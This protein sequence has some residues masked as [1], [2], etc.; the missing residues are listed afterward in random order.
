MRHLPTFVSVEP[1]N[2]CNLRCP[3]CPVGMANGHPQSGKAEMLRPE[4]WKT[5]LR[6][7]APYAHTMQFYFQ[8]E[9]L[10]NPD[11]PKMIHEAH[12]AGLYTIVST[13]AQ[14]ITFGLA[15]ALVRSGLNRI[16]VSLDGISQ[17]S[18]SAYRVGGDIEKVR[19]ALRLLHDVKQRLGS[20][21]PVI[22]WQCLR[23]HTNEHEWAEMRRVYRRWGADRITLKTAQLYDY[24]NGN[25]LMPADTRYA[26][27][28]IGKDGK[29]HLK[30]SLWRR[31]WGISAPC[32]RL[33]SGCVITT[34]GEVLP[35]CYDKA[36]AHPF[37]NILTAS[38]ATL[39]HSSVANG[40]RYSV[41][42]NKDI[43]ICRNCNR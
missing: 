28:T 18:Y 6:E 39:F 31:L 20:R 14:G 16:I 38:F 10:L 2:F 3:E 33:W 35:C 21:T 23:L 12:E 4:V 36:H 32:C 15:E 22:E 26:R 43:A 8:G 29:Y 24:A 41:L 5:L 27:Y 42:R 25:P 17:Q 19:E 7:I 30:Q 13:N 40:F 37:G 9:P 34:S 11:L 1:A